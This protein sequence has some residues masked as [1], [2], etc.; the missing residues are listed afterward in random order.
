[1]VKFVL[2]VSDRYGE[3]VVGERQLRAAHA[4]DLLHGRVEH[5]VAVIVVAQHAA[6]CAHADPYSVERCVQRIDAARGEES[7]APSN[8]SSVR[9]PREAVTPD[10]SSA[11]HSAAHKAHIVKCTNPIHVRHIP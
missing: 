4:D 3:G 2:R 7:A 8:G 1:M 11:T 5:H 10:S 9:R 6:H